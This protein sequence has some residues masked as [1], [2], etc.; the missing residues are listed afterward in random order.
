M[1][2]IPIEFR[3]MKDADG[4]D[5]MKAGVSIAY[6]SNKE[7]MD[8][9]QMVE[10]NFTKLQ[11]TL[12]GKIKKLHK[13]ENI[14]AHWEI[15]DEVYIFFKETEDVG[16][17]VEFR[18]NTLADYI[19]QGREFWRHHLN[20]RTMYPTK[21]S[22]NQKVP[23]T[24][25]MELMKV[26]DGTKRKELELQVADGKIK[27]PTGLGKGPSETHKKI[28]EQLKKSA[29]SKKE[30]SD[31]TGVKE[32]SIQKRVSDLRQLGYNIALINGKYALDATPAVIAK[33]LVVKSKE[34]S[35]AYC[36]KSAT[37]SIQILDKKETVCNNDCAKKLIDKY[38]SLCFIKIAE[39][40][41]R[42]LELENGVE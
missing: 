4:K 14:M 22:V 15:G 36:N 9:I 38:E 16:L 17:Q 34:R 21:E 37:M 30:I 23:W 29:Q 12:Q 8:K 7:I 31:A 41:K 24:M 26:K 6:A 27:H 5:I 2:L 32:I 25:Y 19:G 1:A 33:E 40:K 20:F 11:K 35:C 10:Q 13:N 3:P 18:I 42:K 28:L 39:L